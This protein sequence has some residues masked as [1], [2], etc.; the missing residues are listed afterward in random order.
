MYRFVAVSEKDG[1]K[2]YI[3]VIRHKAK[4]KSKA[5]LFKYAFFLFNNIVVAYRV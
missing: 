5:S 4:V 2:W 3:I 1:L